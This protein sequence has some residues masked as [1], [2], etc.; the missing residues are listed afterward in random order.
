MASKRLVSFTG[1]QN[2]KAWYTIMAH[3]ARVEIHYR[4]VTGISFSPVIS[5]TLCTI[6]LFYI[7]KLMRIPNV[8][9]QMRRLS[10]HRKRRKKLQCHRLLCLKKGRRTQ[11]QT[12]AKKVPTMKDRRVRNIHTQCVYLKFLFYFA[13]LLSGIVHYAC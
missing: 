3:Y 11:N 10:A 5:N 13:K 9:S 1:S 12:L 6:F 4:L 7:H 8:P 2:V